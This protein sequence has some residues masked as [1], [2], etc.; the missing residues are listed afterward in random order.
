MRM[1]QGEGGRYTE[2]M[3][4]PLIG[5][6]AEAP[7]EQGLWTAPAPSAQA[8]W[9]GQGCWPRVCRGSGGPGA[10]REVN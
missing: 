4:S 5:C 7:S 9:E 3:A 10:S 1:G 6:E 8:R 2:N